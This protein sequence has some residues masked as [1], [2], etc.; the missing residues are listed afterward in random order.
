MDVKRIR[1]LIVGQGSTRRS[2]E[3]RV[4]DSAD[5]ILF[6]IDTALGCCDAITDSISGLDYDSFLLDKRTMK[7]VAMDMQTIGNFMKEMPEEILSYAPQ[8]MNAYGFRCIIAHDYGNASF[9]F[10]TLWDACV[11]DVPQMQKAL[12]KAKEQ[13][14]AEGV[15]FV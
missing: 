13:I 10:P 11:Y 8:L 12:E 2:I 14:L 4:Y 1:T 15:R 6:A 7:A 5:K 9:D 3:I